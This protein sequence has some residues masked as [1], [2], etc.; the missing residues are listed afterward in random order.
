MAEERAV[1]ADRVLVVLRELG[2]YPEGIALD[3]LALALGEPKSS[4][5]R[6]LSTLRKRGF[7]ATD[8]RGRYA[9]GDELLRLAFS[10]Q[11]NRPERARIEPVLARLTV[12]F[13]ETAHFAVLDGAEVVYRAKVDPPGGGMRLTSVV[14]GRN[15]AHATGV[16]KLL[17]ANSFRDQADFAEWVGGRVLE[18]RTSSTITEP[19]ALWREC[20]EIQRLGYAVD[21]QE[22]EVGVE[23][24]AFPVSLDTPGR[25]DG[26]VS[27]SAIAVRTSARVL[28]ERAP[29]I[30][31]ALGSIAADFASA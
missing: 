3:E 18:S 8:S 2:R 24:I 12:M 7:A 1:G 30:R 21:R 19:G 10:V 27:V 11:Q 13:G 22:S 23:C 20:E 9:V 4:V 25:I 6:A 31:E 28:L 17:L 29:E 26:A 16:G 5:H 15:P 14:G